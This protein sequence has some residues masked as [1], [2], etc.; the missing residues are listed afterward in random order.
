MGS[1]QLFPRI[2]TVDEANRLLPLIRPLVEQ[3]FSA[4]ESLRKV[5]ETVI[6]QESLSPSSPDLMDRLQRNELIARLILQVKGL[7]E[8]IQSFGCVCKGVEEGLVDFPCFLGGEV[9]FLCWRYGE[10]SIT[11][12][13]RVQDGFAGR[14]GLLDSDEEPGGG[15]AS[16]H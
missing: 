11:Y 15:S 7:V 5:S 16:Y 8:E 14:K 3:I 13:H 12:W 4:L 6:R 2:F 1:S 9:V 10:E